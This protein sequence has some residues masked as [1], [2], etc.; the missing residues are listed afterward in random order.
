M[1]KT[2]QNFVFCVPMV[3][4]SI[5]GKAIFPLQPKNA[6]HREYNSELHPFAAFMVL[7]ANSG[8]HRE[9]VR[10]KV[11]PHVLRASAIT[12]LKQQGLS[13]RDVGKTTGQT[14]EMVNTYDKNSR[15]ENASKKIQLVQ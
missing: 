11:T 15:A 6:W 4:G 12:Y 1:Q 10:L 3:V 9:E 8:K 5:C 13:N 14:D 7:A 2:W